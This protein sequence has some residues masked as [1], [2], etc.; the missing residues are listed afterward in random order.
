M[1]HKLLTELA[2]EHEKKSSLAT[3]LRELYELRSSSEILL[4]ASA[5]SKRATSKTASQLLKTIFVG[6]DVIFANAVAR[7]RE[8]F[9]E[10]IKEE[11][12]HCMLSESVQDVHEAVQQWKDLCR[13]DFSAVLAS[14][15]MM[16]MWIAVCVGE[17]LCGPASPREVRGQVIDAVTYLLDSVG[18]GMIAGEV[19]MTDRQAQS[20]LAVVAS[21]PINSSAS[22]QDFQSTAWGVL[23]RTYPRTEVSKWL[24]QGQELCVLRHAIAN[25]NVVHR[26]S[27]DAPGLLETVMKDLC[28]DHEDL[29]QSAAHVIAASMD[30]ATPQP[31]CS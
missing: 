22:I 30:Q 11:L 9:V 8:S 10:L 29:R 12:Q 7:G 16:L 20:L 18:E 27:L 28:E 6:P 5:G 31:R 19:H 17:R 14:L 21:M 23:L 24:L 1:C 13:H 26:I 15:D 3:K 2:T 25:P 4:A